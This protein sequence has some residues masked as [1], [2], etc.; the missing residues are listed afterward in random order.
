MGYLSVNEASPKLP[1]VLAALPC[2]ASACSIAMGAMVLL[3]WALNNEILKRVAPSYVAMNPTTALLFVCAGVAFLAHNLKPNLAAITQIGAAF[4]IAVAGSKLVDLIAQT[5][6]DLDQLLFTAKLSD[7][8]DQLPNRMAPNT[9]VDFVMI[10]LA[11]HTLRRSSKDFCASQAFAIIAA[12]GALL[13]LT[14]YAYGVRSFS[15]IASFI[16]MAV[17]TASTFFVLSIGLFFAHRDTSVAEVFTANDSR[18]VLARRL[19]PLAVLATLFLGWARVY[20]ERLQLYENEFGTALFAITLT[21]LLIFL[22]RWTVRTIGRLET[23]RAEALA[24]LH[25]ANRRK[26]EMIAVVSH[27]LCTPLTGFRMVIDLLRE[28]GTEPPEDL[29]NLMDHSA[30]RM[31]SMVR[32]L[33]DVAKLESHK[34]ELE[35]EELLLS[36]LVRQSLEPLRINANAK[37]IALD[38]QVNE[39]ETR[40]RGDRLR[41]AQVFNNLLSNAVKFTNPGGRVTV[42]VDPA[43]DGTRVVVQDTG[44]GIPRQD[45][46]HIF[47]KYYQ[48]SSKPTAGEKGTGLGLAIVREVVLLHEGRIDVRSEPGSGTSFIIYLPRE[49]RTNTATAGINRASSIEVTTAAPTTEL[50][51]S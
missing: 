42:H 4:I 17:H 21:V 35:R 13:P 27:D 19:F 2:I 47:D 9:A 10:G 16:P 24:R 32:G 29:L 40:I 49:P 31:V 11:L 1:A 50:A 15:G 26:D 7:A 28:G 51:S 30:R 8:R 23:E 46:P 5:H 39:N 44:L 45:L 20:G 25:D 38:L 3:G 22:V 18:G 48:A 34:I 36:E 6:F 12:F 14:G 41:L 33:L 37:H 43:A